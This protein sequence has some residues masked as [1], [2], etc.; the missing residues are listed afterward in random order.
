MRGLPLLLGAVLA[1]PVAA[2]ANSS[3]SAHT[4]VVATVDGVG[5]PSSLFRT[6]VRSGS[7]ALRLDKTTEEGH[8]A[9]LALEQGVLDELIDRTLVAAEAR[10]RGLV[11]GDADVARRLDQLVA[12]I[13]GEP[14]YRSY[15]AEHGLSDAEFRGSIE[16]ELLGLR[17][18]TEL[19]RGVIA[20]ESELRSAF[21]EERRN[22]ALRALFVDP[23]QVAASHILIAARPALIER[24]LRARGLSGTAVAE[25]VREEM[26]R[27][28]QRAEAVR[29]RAAA[30]KDFALLARE[31]SEDPSSRAQGGDL[32]AFARGIHTKS[33]DDAAF[34]LPPGSVS[35]VVQTEYGYHVIV[36]RRHQPERE[37]RLEE[38]RGGLEARLLSRKRA[39]HLRSWLERRR[40]NAEV[41]VVKPAGVSSVP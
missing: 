29:G 20:S 8:K 31:L 22:P 14:G 25:A 35:P 28:R 16:Q 13:G 32:G 6:Y 3:P 7:E 10:R 18:Q 17:L 19:T 15:L 12:Q 2:S 11:V 21:A 30:G 38:V 26:E 5:I 4:A 34:A 37:R 33:F 36:V 41:R 1:F 9:L 23:E 39:Q 27:R 24:D 40:R